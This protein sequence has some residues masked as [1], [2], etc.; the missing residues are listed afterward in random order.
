MGIL[1]LFGKKKEYETADVYLR[2]RNQIFSLT[3][4]QIDSI[5]EPS[6]PIIAVL[7]EFG[8]EEAVVTLV[9]VADGTV[10]IYVSNGAGFIGMGAHA[11]VRNTA[12]DFLS[13]AERFIPKAAPAKDHPLPSKGFTT[14]YFLTNTGV[15]F[16]TGREKDFEK[17]QHPLFLKALAVFNEAQR[18]EEKKQKDFQQLMQAATAGNE[19]KVS[20]LLLT[21]PHPDVSD[22]TGL[23]PLMAAAYSGHDRII[24]K[25]LDRQALIDRKDSEGYTA[26]MFACKAG[27]LAC[28]QVL[29]EYGA[30]VNETDKD[31]STP[32]MFAAQ[33]GYNDIVRYLLGRG[34]DPAFVGKHGLSAIGFARQNK[35]AETEKILLGQK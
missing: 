22:S 11:S 31:N 21:L 30:N 28:V 6:S 8:Y 7:V 32:L 13:L 33:H 12:L 3:T 24:K 35:F 9:T 18:I 17:K 2:L 14:F 27:K 16:A 15:F 34:A 26:L 5:L 23:T 25:L 29:L 1:N 10:S 20:E 19:A 4:D